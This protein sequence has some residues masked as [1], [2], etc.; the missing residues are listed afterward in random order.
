MERLRAGEAGAAVRLLGDARE[1]LSS[2]AAA[3]RAYDRGQPVTGAAGHEYPDLAL[4]E[5]VE[6]PYA[7]VQ[8]FLCFLFPLSGNVG[9]TCG[10]AVISGADRTSSSK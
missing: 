9:S 5:A 2:C 6:R 10:K 8:S 3:A 7:T 1:L 4:K